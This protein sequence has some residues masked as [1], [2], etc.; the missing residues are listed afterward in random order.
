MTTSTAANEAQ[1][2]PTS[3][4]PRETSVELWWVQQHPHPAI[5]QRDLEARHRLIW[6]F[7]TAAEKSLQ[8]RA[9]KIRDCCAYPTIRVRADGNTFFSPARCRDRLC[10]LCARIAAR[11]TSQR[12]KSVISRWDQC[13]HLTLTL[14]STDDPLT[15]QIDLLL[16]SF[17]RLR[18]RRWWSDRV[19]GGI[20]TVEVT[21]NEST[22]RWHPHLHLLLNGT[23]LPQAELSDQWVGVTGDSSIVHITAVHS[24]KDA[25]G[26]VAK[27]VSKPAD[28]AQLD[29]PQ[30]VELALAL[31]GRRTVI[32]FGTAHGD[33]LPVRQ[34]GT[35]DTGSSHVVS[36]VELKMGLEADL[37]S[38]KWA[39]H[40][41]HE[42][43]S[44]IARILDQPG[45]HQGKPPD[46]DKRLTE[47]P[48]IE[49]LRDCFDWDSH[50]PTPIRLMGSPTRVVVEDELFDDTEW[51]KRLPKHI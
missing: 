13:R 17:R 34:K 4:D 5:H 29:Q 39:L 48:L 19:A 42:M 7:A 50:H 31:A 40:R 49:L 44:P 11:Q 32:A 47:A 30:A 22:G 36:L 14:K 46:T 45:R 27:Y 2:L 20:G 26:Y 8:K 51:A 25:A 9:E 18:Q 24:R 15:M 35:D 33:G 28:V 3:L 1:A 43:G 12:V 21:F 23:Y 6:T 16:R 10:P 37:P 38:A 41:L